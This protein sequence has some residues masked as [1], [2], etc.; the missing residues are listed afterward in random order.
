MIA[1]RGGPIIKKCPP[2]RNPLLEGMGLS[3]VTIL[4]EG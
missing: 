3:L 1:A 2:L 4:Q